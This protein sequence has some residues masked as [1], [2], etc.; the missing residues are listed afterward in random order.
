MA[1]AVH[2]AIAVTTP[3]D[4]GSCSGSWDG[5]CVRAIGN[6][7]RHIILE[8][9][10]TITC[11][12]QWEAIFRLARSASRKWCWRA[13]ITHSNIS[14]TEFAVTTSFAEQNLG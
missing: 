10:T 6:V 3:L 2:S 8:P 1:V 13:D 9:T 12:P 7:S 11:L 5:L 14:D 4:R